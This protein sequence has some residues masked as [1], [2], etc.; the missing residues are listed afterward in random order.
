MRRSIGLLLLG[1]AL[2]CAGVAISIHAGKAIREELNSP[3]KADTT[4]T[5]RLRNQISSNTLELARIQRDVLS[6]NALFKAAFREVGVWTFTHRAANGSIIW[7]EAL[8]NALM[9]AGEQRVLEAYFRGGAIV[10]HY[11][12]LSDATNPCSIAETDS[13]ATAMTG[14]PSGNGYS[15]VNITRDATGWPTSALDSGDWRIVSKTCT[16]TSTG[17]IGPVNCAVLATTTDN[18]GDPIAFVALSQARTMA[19]GESLDVSMAIKQ[20]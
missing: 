13:L 6:A 8:H 4:A 11:L 10:G 20:Q 1:V 5:D 2:V 17:T 9:D 3:S 7:R 14:E 18:T 16:F 15:R 12:G 19:N